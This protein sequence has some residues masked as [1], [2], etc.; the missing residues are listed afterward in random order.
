VAAGVEVTGRA[1]TPR[2]REQDACRPSRRMPA[3]RT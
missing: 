3:R 1:A 2:S